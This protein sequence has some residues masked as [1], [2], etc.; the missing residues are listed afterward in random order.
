[1]TEKLK[2]TDDFYFSVVDDSFS[3]Y[4]ISSVETPKRVRNDTAN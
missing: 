4:A 2:F 1:M 3:I